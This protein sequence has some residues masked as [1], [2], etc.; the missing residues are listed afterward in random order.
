MS[1]IVN[2]ILLIIALIVIIKTCKNVERVIENAN[3]E[4]FDMQKKLTQ[5]EARNTKMSIELMSVK[6]RI[7][8]LEI[9][10]VT[11]LVKSYIDYDD[12]Y[13]VTLADE[14][15]ISFKSITYVDESVLQECISQLEKDG[16][17]CELKNGNLDIKKIA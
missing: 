10:I 1:D 3:T 17:K 5:L 13:T 6:L 4:V 9:K 11:E 12:I 8:K 7:W 15:F 16:C 2:L 14:I